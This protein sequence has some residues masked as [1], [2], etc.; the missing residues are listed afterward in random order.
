MPLA[1]KSEFSGSRRGRMLRVTV[2]PLLFLGMWNVMT[3]F[4]TDSAETPAKHIIGATATLTEVSSGISFPARIDTGARSCSLHVE[5]IEIEEKDKKRVRNIGKKIRFL[6]KD[7]NGGTHWLEGEIASAIRVKS[8]SLKA[9]EYDHRYK[10]RLT[11]EWEGF[12]KKVL[13]SLNDRTDMEYPLLVGRNFLRGDFLV[14]V[15]KSGKA[16]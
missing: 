10:V 15:A 2:L 3:A 9:G 7:N 5:K 8:S 12:S 1:G 6:V 13:V 14:D 11:L 16:K 4:G